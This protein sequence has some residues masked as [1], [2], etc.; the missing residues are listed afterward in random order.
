MIYFN[1]GKIMKKRI[2]SAIVALIIVVPLIILGNYF[3]AFGVCVIAMLAYKELI[4]LKK[5]HNEYPKLMITLGLLSMLS[6]V[7]S[8]Y[9]DFTIYRGITYQVIAMILLLLLIPIIFYRKD[10]YTSRDAFYLVGITLLLGIIFNIFIVIRNRGLYLFI[11]L[12]LIPMVTDIFAMLG[13][14]YFGKHKMCPKLSPKKTWE[15][16]ISGTLCGSIV[17]IVFYSLLVGNL[18]FRVVIIT[19]LLSIVGQMGDLV[20]SKIKRENDIKDFSNIMPGHGGILDRIDSIIF[21][22]LMYMFLLII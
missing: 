13:G 18:T 1:R 10:K 3:F 6:L 17:G 20:M 8:N 4:D 16:A 9:Q 11:Y 7:L 2:I 21:V 15:G 5:S 12:L 19:I 14:K 22:F